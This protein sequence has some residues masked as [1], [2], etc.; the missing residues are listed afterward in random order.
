M[1]VLQ[2]YG[3]DRG[4]SDRGLSTSLWK[5]FGIDSF[6]DNPRVGSFW[7]DPMESYVQVD[8]GSNVRVITGNGAYINTI[9]GSGTIVQGTAGNYGSLLFDTGATTSGQ[10]VQL[11]GGLSVV[12]AAGIEICFEALVKVITIT[13]GPQFLIGLMSP[14]N[15]AIGGGATAVVDADE[16]AICFTTVTGNDG[17]TA[18]LTYVDE[19]G[20]AQVENTGYHTLVTDTYVKLGCRINGVT[21]VDWWTDG[22]E[23]TAFAHLAAGQSTGTIPTVQMLPT[24]VMQTDG[25]VQGTAELDWWAVGVRSI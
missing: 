14:T 24:M 6:S 15:V 18:L 25:T 2:E 8:E 23:K 4:A 5:G 17:G 7:Y 16:D 22:V 10:G 3:F 9:V 12:P 13:T 11:Q 20:E 21:G 1:S 19:S